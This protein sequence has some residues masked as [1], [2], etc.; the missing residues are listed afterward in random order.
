MIGSAIEDS[1]VAALLPANADSARTVFVAASRN[2]RL[3][4]GVPAPGATAVTAALSVSPE[5]ASAVLLCALFTICVR[6]AEP[7]A[8]EL[9]SPDQIAVIECVPAER[10]AVT[11]VATPPDICAWPIAVAPSENCTVPAGATPCCIPNCAV[12]VTGCP[13]TVVLK[14]EVRLSEITDLLITCWKLAVLAG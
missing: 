1:G 4:V 9:S 10:F 13:Y 12:N 6:G 2:R 3:P 14:L 7:A 5:I 11:S 8:A